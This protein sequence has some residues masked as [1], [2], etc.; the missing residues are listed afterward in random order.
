MEGV[1][2]PLFW[3]SVLYPTAIGLF[4]LRL[5][6][7]GFSLQ[8]HHKCRA[9]YSVIK[10]WEG[11]FHFANHSGSLRPFL[12]WCLILSFLL[13]H[14][15]PDVYHNHV[16]LSINKPPL[17]TGHWLFFSVTEWTFEWP[18]VCC[19]CCL[20][21]EKNVSV[22]LASLSLLS[23]LQLITPGNYCN[24][25][26]VQYL[27]P[28]ECRTHCPWLLNSPSPFP[29]SARVL[30]LPLWHRSGLCMDIMKQLCTMIRWGEG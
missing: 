24:T 17:Y 22:L 3:T 28:L 25:Q 5:F 9:P 7:F 12:R 1:D 16:Y 8:D 21:E 18:S 11:S 6:S 29:S 10:S 13:W 2:Y 20:G 27:P 15:C 19:D 14:I 30:P 26:H 4:S 23:Q